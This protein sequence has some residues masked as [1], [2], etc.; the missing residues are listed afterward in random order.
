MQEGSSRPIGY[1]Q[2]PGRVATRVRDFISRYGERAAL[3]H[4]RLSRLT[5]ARAAGT[6]TV[7][8]ST[9]LALLDGVARAESMDESAAT[10]AEG[11]R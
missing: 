5:L 4:F 6:L 1:V 7:Q 8:R 3:A 2:V 11:A 10:E 9:L